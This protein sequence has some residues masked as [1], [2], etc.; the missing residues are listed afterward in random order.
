[1]LQ[2]EN[3]IKGLDTLRFFAFVFVFLSHIQYYFPES[4]LLIFVALKEFAKGGYLGVDLFFVLS[5]FLLSSISL[6]EV[7]ETGSF[8][9]KNYLK[10]R[11]LRILPLY[12]FIVLLTFLVP[13]IQNALDV[14]VSDLPSLWYFIS[15]Q[16]NFQATGGDEFLMI[17]L[18]SISVEV[19]FYLINALALKYLRKYFILFNILIIGVTLIFRYIYLD[20]LLMLHYHTLSVAACFAFGNLLAL[21]I[22]KYPNLKYGTPFRIMIIFLTALLL[23]FYPFIQ[24]LKFLFWAEKLIYPFFFC[25]IILFQTQKGLF[26]FYNW[27]KANYL[28]KISYGLY[29]YHGF[30]IA[31]L[32]VLFNYFFNLSNIIV[33]GIAFP[34]LAFV[35]TIIVSAISYQYFEKRFLTLKPKK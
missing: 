3:Y 9:L 12:L 15:F 24:Q 21:F 27:K 29:C 26:N 4:N 16:L 18:W 7:T 19:Q 25:C 35:C 10:R 22:N 6:N 23:I 14:R 33:Y 17:I 20:N 34:L 1:M 2:K 13:I 30:T 5:A 32:A 31:T 8:S 11:G 28:G